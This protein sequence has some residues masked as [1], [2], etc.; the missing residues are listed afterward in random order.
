MELFQSSLAA[1]DVPDHR[2]QF[3][4]LNRVYLYDATVRG[5]P[6]AA[7]IKRSRLCGRRWR[8]RAN[9]K[10]LANEAV[11]LQLLII[12]NVRIFRLVA[13]LGREFRVAGMN[14]TRVV[15]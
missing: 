1:N 15:R 8:P 14:V 7:K 12:S 4:H 2:V 10:V 5:Q 6:P 11:R 13:E 9:L 3:F